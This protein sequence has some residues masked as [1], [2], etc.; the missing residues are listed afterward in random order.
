MEK[1]G[2]GGWRVEMLLMFVG[3]FGWVGLGWF[4]GWF[5]G[6]FGCLVWFGWLVG[7]LVFVVCHLGAMD[8]IN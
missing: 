5:F 8:W 2:G 7:C 3:L 6:L 4:V 1:I